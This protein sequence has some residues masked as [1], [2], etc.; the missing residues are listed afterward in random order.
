M[1]SQAN[2][3]ESACLSQYCIEWS[4]LGKIMISSNQ[5][6]DKI[7]EIQ[8]N[9]FEKLE[10]YFLNNNDRIKEQKTKKLPYK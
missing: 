1:R 4:K 6:S 9:S 10:M 7:L 3:F 8:R 5:I 2:T